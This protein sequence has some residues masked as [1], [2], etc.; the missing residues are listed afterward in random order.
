MIYLLAWL[1]LSCVVAPLIG[2][3]IVYGTGGDE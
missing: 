2:A 3:C 1:A